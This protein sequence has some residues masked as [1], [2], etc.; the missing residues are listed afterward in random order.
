MVIVP[1][2]PGVLR[3]QLVELCQFLA[4]AIELRGDT[5]VQAD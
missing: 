2:N 4:T 1:Q 3:V 5:V